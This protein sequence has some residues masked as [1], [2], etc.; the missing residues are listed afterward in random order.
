L[1]ENQE[2]VEQIAQILIE[3][4]VLFAD[5]VKEI[6]GERPWKSRG[7]QLLNDSEKKS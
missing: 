5:D 4:E 6:L 2:G 7:E 1:K 3:R